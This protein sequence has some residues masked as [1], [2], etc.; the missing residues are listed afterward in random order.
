[1]ILSRIGEITKSSYTYLQIFDKMKQS[2]ARDD[3]LLYICIYSQLFSGTTVMPKVTP[4]FTAR[5][6]AKG[7]GH[8]ASDNQFIERVHYWTREGLLVP[9][10]EVNPGTGRRRFYPKTA[11]QEALILDA[12]MDRGVLVEDQRRVMRALRD[13][14]R[15]TPNL[16][17]QMKKERL[18]L[19]IETHQGKSKPYFHE[20][21]YTM[22]PQFSDAIVFNLTDLFSNLQDQT[23]GAHG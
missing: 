6:I 2:L 18:F 1:M 10:G 8:D 17:P 7:T 4:L 13:R 22:D 14:R 19:A 23:G 3:L 20:G 16:W 5:D 9:V 15:Q 12:M 21:S 11:F